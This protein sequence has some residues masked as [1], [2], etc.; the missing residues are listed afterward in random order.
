MN[1]DTPLWLNLRKEYIDDNFESLLTYLKDTANRKDAFYTTTM[2]LLRQRVEMQVEGIASRP[3]TADE[4]P[5]QT[6]RIFNVRLL[7]AWILSGALETDTHAAFSAM[8]GELRMLVPKY[9]EAL[10]SLEMKVL[11]HE[12]MSDC[13]FSWDDVINFSM[14][15]FAYKVISNAKP[16]IPRMKN[17]WWTGYGSAF[18]NSDN[19]CL[20]PTGD[21]KTQTALSTIPASITTEF[22]IRVLYNGKDKLKQSQSEDVT[23]IDEFRKVF[24][25]EM[26]RSGVTAPK[27]HKLPTYNNGQEVTVRVVEVRNNTLYVKTVDP[28]HTQLVGPLVFDR[29]SLVYYYPNQIARFLREGDEFIAKVRDAAAQS[30]SIEDTF[31]DYIVE[32]C[33][34]D[35]DEDVTAILIDT[36]QREYVWLTDMGTPVYTPKDISYHKGD[37]ATIRI[38][39]LGHGRFLGKIDGVIVGETDD[40]FIEADV[41]K[42]CVEG[43]RTEPQELQ[44]QP[45]EELGPSL[46]ATCLRLL[47]RHLFAHQAHLMKPSEKIRLL[48]IARILAEMQNDT[49][50]AQYIDFVSSYQRALVLFAKDEDLSHV[51]LV[52]PED[53]ESSETALLRKSVV[54]LL[55]QWG[56]DG[57]N[58]ALTQY[59]SWFEESKPVLARIARIIQTSN[60]MRALV[61]DASLNVL[62]REVIK[63]LQL[64]IGDESDLEGEKGIYLGIESGSVEFKESVVF[65]P[66]NN[67]YPNEAVQ[68][69]NVLKGVCAFMNSQMGGTL[70]LGVS[71]QGYVKGIQNDLDYLR[72]SSL[73]T[74]MRVHIQDPAKRLLGL[75]AIANMRMEPM[76]DN[77]VIAIHVEPAQN[78]IIRLEDKAYIRINAESREM[79]ES[80]EQQMLGKKVFSNKE[81]AVNLSI[82]QQAAQE[83]MQVVLRNYASSNS[84]T[85]SD[86]TVEAYGYDPDAN[87]AFCLDTNDLACKV[88]SLS[89]IG[90]VEITDKPWSHKHL[91]KQISIDA[92][93]MSGEKRIRCCLELDMMA[94]NL[95]LEEFPKTKPDIRRNGNRNSWTLDTCVYSIPGIARFY[96]G[97]ANHIT[98]LDAPELEAYVRDFVKESLGGYCD[99]TTK[100]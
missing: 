93:H 8:L 83:Q 87:V 13:G 29:P 74:Y 38:R 2:Q 76:Y 99:N 20:L 31:V 59:I 16:L 64:E 32:D 67:M 88:F 89:R 58:E 26:K 18:V 57:D 46:N 72:I 21:E 85:I 100:K 41:R 49:S 33:K 36:N 50:A 77:Q 82:I 56:E 24:L 15:I 30:F 28:N 95:L 42:K 14:E 25:E 3:L 5:L 23:A 65:P 53:C 96:L 9:S 45:Q 62:K 78:R 7:G 75:D 43:F 44:P 63:A 92:F 37:F 22:G 81:K 48:T 90:F 91:H 94:K 17:R 35:I 60:N 98:I 80:M 12:S 97:L 54:Q 55:Q 84:A 11:F 51:K 68:I 4:E 66:D 40:R 6:A 39:S 61:T 79:P 73:D 71:D 34:E 19:L 52:M 70:Y 1:T 27:V 47:L 69:K 86:R 10:L